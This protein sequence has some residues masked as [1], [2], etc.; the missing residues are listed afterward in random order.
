MAPAP[1]LPIILISVFVGLGSGALGLYLAYGALG[2]SLP[3]S[4]AFATL[5]LLMGL[6]ASA[7]GLSSLEGTGS[8]WIN[9][10]LSC[11]LLL[12][13]LIYFGFCLLVGAVAATLALL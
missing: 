8:G 12:L 3:A 1:S 7:G 9:L 4:A 5:T 10:G 6:A 13:L 2:W 11:G